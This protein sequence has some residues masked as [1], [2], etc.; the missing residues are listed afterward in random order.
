[1]NA[2]LKKFQTGILFGN[3]I[4]N[5][6]NNECPENFFDSVWSD[7]SIQNEYV[8]SARIRKRSAHG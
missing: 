6:L 5:Q 4:V 8:V 1:M 3:S 2:C 7:K